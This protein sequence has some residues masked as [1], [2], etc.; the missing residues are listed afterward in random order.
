MQP[1]RFE[2]FAADNHNC[3]LIDF[4]ITLIDKID[5]SDHTIRED[6]TIKVMINLILFFCLK[7]FKNISF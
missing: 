6:I 7:G 5:G 4:S 2:N 3:F 1:E